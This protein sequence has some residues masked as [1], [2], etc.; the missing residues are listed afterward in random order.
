MKRMLFLFFIAL[1]V[2]A[3]PTLEQI[4]AIK[5]L[6]EKQY[7]AQIEALRNH[8]VIPKLGSIALPLCCI[9]HLFIASEWSSK[10][11]PTA[12]YVTPYMLGWLVSFYYDLKNQYQA[13]HAL[14]KAQR[15]KDLT[16]IEML[17]LK[18]I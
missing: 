16:N 1:S 3:K 17:K 12:T 15:Y 2:Q 6:R 8:K 9:A 14:I 10:P 11:V 13:N 5:L 4:D 7:Q 18:L